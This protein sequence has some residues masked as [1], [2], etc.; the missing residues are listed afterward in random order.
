MQKTTSVFPVKVLNSPKFEKDMELMC[1]NETGNDLFKSPPVF[2][3]KGAY[4][5][6]FV[7][8]MDNKLVQKRTKLSDDYYSLV[9]ILREVHVLK[10]MLPGCVPLHSIHVDGCEAVVCMDRFGMDLR[11]YLSTD[12]VPR[13][14]KVVYNIIKQVA[15]ALYFMHKNGVVHRDLKPGNILVTFHGVQP[16]VALCDF[17]LSRQ[18]CIKGQCY[19]GYVITKWYRPPELN[20][21]L[22][23]M[24]KQKAVEYVN[25]EKMDIWSFGCI[26]VE[27][28]TLKPFFQ[29]QHEKEF[30][31]LLGSMTKRME[32]CFSG[33]AYPLKL[34][35]NMLQVEPE[36]RWDASTILKYLKV[37]DV[38]KIRQSFYLGN[39]IYDK[40]INNTFASLRPSYG[41]QVISYAKM[42]YSLHGTNERDLWACIAY[43]YCLFSQSVDSKIHDILGKVSQSYIVNFVSGIGNRL[44]KS[45]FELT[46]KNLQNQM[47]NKKRKIRKVD[48][49]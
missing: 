38:P 46:T 40:E 19:S 1:S 14:G 42:I 45:E 12:N 4:G 21:G 7:H 33:K 37:K 18:N 15:K 20:H 22:F 8:P 41:S 28:F 2:L 17:G 9:A 29:Y 5:N 35:Q 23:G 47:S 43:A 30:M 36:K 3:G 31:P 6:V 13:S 10:M 44:P 11:H 25:S 24:N 48:S 27:L 26:I 49:P 34:V 32:D 39:T 16:N